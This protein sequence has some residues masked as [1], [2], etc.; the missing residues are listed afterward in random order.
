M[1]LN[2]L[3]CF[4]L[5]LVVIFFCRTRRHKQICCKHKQ[6]HISCWYISIT[7]DISALQVRQDHVNVENVEH[8]AEGNRTVNG[9]IGLYYYRFVSRFGLKCSG[10][11]PVAVGSSLSKADNV[12]KRKSISLFSKKHGFTWHN[13]HCLHGNAETRENAVPGR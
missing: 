12:P 11:R 5:I 4:S 3:A 1:L 13:D 10:N 7:A 9:R 2:T 8:K 6:M